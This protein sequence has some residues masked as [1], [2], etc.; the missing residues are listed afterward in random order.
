MAA[1]KC[2]TNNLITFTVIVSLV[3]FLLRPPMDIA[4]KSKQCSKDEPKKIGN[5]LARTEDG[6]GHAKAGRKALT[7]CDTSKLF[8]EVYF[9]WIAFVLYSI[10]SPEIVL[11]KWYLPLV[12]VLFGVLQT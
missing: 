7:E 4:H 5:S 3:R 1:I 8:R 11:T 9:N 10:A 6:Q 2:Q 12:Y